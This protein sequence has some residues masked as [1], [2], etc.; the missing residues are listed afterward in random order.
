M[1]GSPEI[2]TGLF[3]GR[4]TIERELGRG[5]T[6]TVYLARDR[7]AERAVAIKVLRP[8]L[9]A[10]MGAERFLREIAVNERLKH[11]N[12]A[13][14]LASGEHDGLLFFVLPHMEGGT[15]RHL[16][17]REK[18]LPV[19]RAVEIA[20][21]IAAALEHAHSQGLI[22]RDI[23][24]ENILFSS[25][26]ACL[27]DFGIAKAIERTIDESTTSTGLIRGTPAYM[28]P[29]QASG[30]KDYDGRSDQYSLACV[31]YE[32]IAG[33]PA[34][35]GPTPEAIIAQRFQHAPRKL[36]IYRSSVSP[37]LEAVVERALAITPADRFASVAAFA[38]SLRDAPRQPTVEAPTQRKSNRVAVFATVA[39]VTGL[40][41]TALFDGK[42]FGGI[43]GRA[44][45]ADTT[46]IAVLPFEETSSAATPPA[47]ELLHAG[48]R[49]WSG[50]TVVPLDETRDAV[51]SSGWNP[52][53]SAG[54]ARDVASRMRA[55]RYV[56]GRI[57]KTPTGQAIAAELRDARGKTVYGAEAPVPSD[58]KMVGVAFAALADSLLL[59]GR[60][61]AAR[62]RV[63]PAVQLF[64]LA[65]DAR[66][67]LDLRSAD[68]L[69]LAALERDKDF[70]QAA[71][72]LAQT[73]VWR[74]QASATWSTWVTRALED[75]TFT[76]SEV[77]TARALSEM[78]SGNAPRACESFRRMAATSPADFQAWYS[79]GNCL[80][81]DTVVVRDTRSPSGWRFRS[82]YHQGV[83][84][85]ARAFELAPA[86][87][88]RFQAGAYRE[89]R[90]L[91][92]TGRAILRP[93]VA[94]APDTGR[95][96]AYASW[97]GDSLLF[98]PYP[99]QSVTSG[100][101]PVD[102]KAWALAIANQRSLFARISRSWAAALP[103]NAGT[104]EA[105]AISLDMLGDASAIDTLQ[106]ARKLASDPAQRQRLA[107]E[108]VILLVARG[109]DDVFSLRRGIAL[110][111]SLLVD[112]STSRS[113]LLTP[114]AA[115]RGRCRI[116]GHFAAT[117]S[118]TAVNEARSMGLSVGTYATAESL[119]AFANMG[120]L[121]SS[122]TSGLLEIERTILR[123]A[124]A[125][126]EAAVGQVRAMLLTRILRVP[127]VGPDWLR[128]T[129]AG[130]GD[131]VLRLQ[132]LIATRDY[133]AA[134]GI[135]EARRAARGLSGTS[136]VSP[137]AVLAEA[138]AWLAMGDSSQ[139][140]RWLDPL[141]ESQNWLELLIV[142]SAAAGALIQACLLRYQLAAASGQADVARKWGSFVRSL[143]DA[144]D[145]EIRKQIRDVR[146]SR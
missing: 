139:A 22:H 70:A 115:L 106:A 138:R 116:A 68:S 5:A 112:G 23:K 51:G 64:E 86:L 98:V 121:T 110:A 132:G 122:D 13:P 128:T 24:P 129:T 125:S 14:V 80:R 12:I 143:W 79:V 97:A 28:S 35:I 111:D 84:A 44:D 11:P 33:V 31:L 59:R 37:G 130:S 107:A 118:A 36:H 72:L 50:I 1:E 96:L 52:L 45:A 92:F 124:E 89:L 146:A 9:A 65:R 95:F 67:A 39:V 145:P 75:S 15:L 58:A 53:Q 140:A 90:N 113:E 34:F 135:L 114:V 17:R 109:R 73:R 71:L 20:R 42:L 55:G 27:A 83:Q 8:E 19:D 120:C 25:G 105:V 7:E 74:H 78:A 29:E 62:S 142:N 136:A 134:R 103:N 47:H 99:R 43:T 108:E 76:A 123:A 93:G 30:S 6:A 32:M 16:M 144:G 127:S 82:S 41:L 48:L 101:A 137:D 119:T 100:I 56:V 49:R 61:T 63:L 66:T 94:A 10:S 85:Y 21:A 38:D 18:Q 2:P 87:H 60:L 4:Y 141:L 54:A 26:E 81:L 117:P 77:T 133:S 126:D 131:Y 57:R 102:A 104:K 46:R 40:V 91:F 88:S 69:L 3:A